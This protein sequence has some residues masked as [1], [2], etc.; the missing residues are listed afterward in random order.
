MIFQLDRDFYE[1]QTAIERSELYSN[2]IANGHYV[3]CEPEVRDLYYESVEA[4][5]SKL[6]RNLIKK[7]PSLKLNRQTRMFLSLMKSADFTPKQLNLIIMKPSRLMVENRVNESPIYRNMI[8]TYASGD[9]AFHN[10]FVK[11]HQ[12]L[13]DGQL[14]FEHGGGCDGYVKQMA[15]MNVNEYKDVAKWK[16]CILSDRDTDDGD[17]YDQQKN[18]LFQLACGK[19]YNEMTEADVYTLDMPNVVWHMWYK[20]AIENYF[21]DSQFLAIHADV[22]TTPQTPADRNYKRLGDMNGYQKNML[23]KLAENMSY[24]MYE[25][26]LKHF[27]VDGKD[28]SEIQ[29]FLLKLLKI[30]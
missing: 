12:A 3:D 1:S 24:A 19:K 23:P 10:A 16:F 2:I 29:L 27:Y 22:S 6:Q 20:R 25:S 28:M 18:P 14:E 26:G 11:L 8:G 21:P 9:R 15:D 17:S 7:D 13:K 4:N 30:I 5:G